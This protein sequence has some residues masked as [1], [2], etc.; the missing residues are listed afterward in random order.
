MVDYRNHRRFMLRCIKASITPVS[1]KLKNPLKT[2]GSYDIIH[3]TEKLLLYKRIRGINKTLAMLD[4]QRENQYIEFKD[5]IFKSNNNNNNNQQHVQDQ[6]KQSDLERSWLF[7]NKIKE[8]CHNKIKEKQIDKFERL[9]FKRYGCHHNLNRHSQIF[10]NI[11]WE[12]NGLSGHQNVPSVFLQPSSHNS[13]NP[14]VPA[15]PRQPPP[16]TTTAASNSNQG[17][18]TSN[19]P[20]TCRCNADKWV[21]NLSNTPSLMNNYPYYKRDQTL[22]SLPNTPHGNLYHGHRTGSFQA[23]SPPSR[24]V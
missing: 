1:C 3:K 18:P 16:S 2:K 11:D 20:H 24:G 7:I 22:P 10:D 12:N 23:S 17:L 13:S 19:N 15:T 8:H 5:A 14:S 9:Y 21:I 4:K 6:D